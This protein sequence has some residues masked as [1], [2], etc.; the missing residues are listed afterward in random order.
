MAGRVPVKH[1]QSLGRFGIGAMIPIF[2]I[3]YVL[4]A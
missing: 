4:R 2:G 3:I 1:T